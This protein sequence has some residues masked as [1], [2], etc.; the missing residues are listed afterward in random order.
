MVERECTEIELT[1]WAIAAAVAKNRDKWRQFIAHPI[2]N[3]GE[4]N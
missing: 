2:L 1:S 3:L 4:R